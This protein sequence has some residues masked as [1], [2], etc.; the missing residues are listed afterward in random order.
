MTGSRILILI[1]HPDDEAV[2]CAVAAARARAEGAGLWGLYLTTGVPARE[3]LWPWQ[4]RRHAER[5]DRR[6]REA[7]RA[8]DALGI[9][10]AGFSDWPARTLKAHLDEALALVERALGDHGI[11]EIWAP[12]WEGGHQDHDAANCLAARLSGRVRVLEFAEY[13]FAGGTVR[14]QAFADPDGTE[15]IL[16]LTSAEALFKGK[17]LA[18]YAS[19]RANLRHIRLERESLR[20][21]PRRDYARAPHGGTLFW[22]RFHWVPFRH[23]RVDFDR[24]EQVRAI[25]A[26]WASRA[27]EPAGPA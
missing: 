5:V 19:E 3:A 24:P 17:L 1:P 10:P 26:A 2:G 22:Q 9:S 16:T 12:A 8:A 4:R 23:P 25:L 7:A 21:L 14:S 13:N 15:Q 27:T 20:L 6:R 18:L 11:D